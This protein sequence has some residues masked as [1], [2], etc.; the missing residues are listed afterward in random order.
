MSV[1]LCPSGLGSFLKPQL[2]LLGLFG[3]AEGRTEGASLGGNLPEEAQRCLWW[4]AS[5]FLSD[6]LL[7]L[8]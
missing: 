5:F 6:F 7:V 3:F 1:R 2:R 4:D 8:L